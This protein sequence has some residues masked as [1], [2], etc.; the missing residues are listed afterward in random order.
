M[1]KKYIEDIIRSSYD[2]Y[3]KNILEKI[4]IINVNIINANQKMSSMHIDNLISSSDRY[5]DP[6]CISACFGQ[7]FSQN[8]E[9]GIISEI[10]NRIGTNSKKFVEIG[11]GDGIENT[12]RLLLE[13]GWSG[14]WLEA[15]RAE[16][17]S[18]RNVV[19]NSIDK[20]D[21]VLIDE[22]VDLENI[23]KLIIS[24]IN[25]KPDYISIDIDY[26][27]SHIWR[28]LAPLQPRVF[29]I[30]YNAHYPPSVSFEVPY[31]NDG[32]WTGTTRFGAS[33]KALETIGREY[34]YS[35]VGCDIFGVN[36]FFVRN[37]LCHDDKFLGPFTAENH[38]EPP[39]FS[40]V[41]MRGHARHPEY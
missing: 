10:F 37:D 6:K 33:L 15:G 26:N 39:R 19:Q 3:T 2:D 31:K 12:T 35:L 20:G 5:K 8:N 16:V 41:H 22:K 29:C 24:R 11:A 27:T 40:S 25:F 7:V 18:I 21:I 36:A 14:L 28:K 13:T 34:G 38:Y 32:V 30:E 23:E 1:F 9:D 4:N 17:A